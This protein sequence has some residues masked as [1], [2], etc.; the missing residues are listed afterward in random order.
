MKTF[1]LR[2]MSP[3]ELE[4]RR[5]ELRE[6]MF[7]LRFAAATRA[8]DNPLRLRSVRREIAK[9]ETVIHEDRIG[10]RALGEVTARTETGGK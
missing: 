7:N 5:A 3:E 2:E 6:E 1:K 9:I 4:Q 10:I 8:L